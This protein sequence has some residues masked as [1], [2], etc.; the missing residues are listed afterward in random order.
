MQIMATSQGLLATA[1]ANPGSSGGSASLAK[2][3]VVNLNV[4]DQVW[5]VLQSGGA[6]TADYSSIFS[7][8]LLGNL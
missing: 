6:L 4:N 7:G 5:I 3:A 2:E 8:Y 1:T